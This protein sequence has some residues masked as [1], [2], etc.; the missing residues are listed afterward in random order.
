MAHLS[1]KKSNWK[2]LAWILEQ[3]G[4]LQIHVLEQIHNEMFRVNQISIY[5][6]VNVMTRSRGFVCL[7]RKTI[8][9]S[10]TSLWAYQGEKIKIS[11]KTNSV[12]KNKLEKTN[13]II[14]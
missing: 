7:E 5:G 6:M 1:S 12:W 3:H 11:D 14:L 9:N 8:Q 10:K 2:R 13:S 4:T